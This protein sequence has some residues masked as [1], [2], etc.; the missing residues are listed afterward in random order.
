MV[1]NAKGLKTEAKTH[2]IIIII[3]IIIIISVP[4]EVKIPGVKYKD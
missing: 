4:Q 3:I 2:V 1:Q